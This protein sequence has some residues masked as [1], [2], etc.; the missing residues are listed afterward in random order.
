MIV[1]QKVSKHYKKSLS[2][3]MALD[4]IDLTVKNNEFVV[5]RGPSGSGK[6]TLLLTI[7][8]MLQP[9]EGR[10]TVAGI[11]PYHIGSKS[12]LAFRAEKIGFVFQLFHLIPYLTVLENVLQPAGA[13]GGGSQE[14]FKTRAKH[15]LEQVKLDVRSDHFP[16]ELSAGEKQRAAIARAMLRKPEILLADEPT[17]NLDPENAAGIARSLAEVHRDGCTVVVVTHGRDCDPY[18]GRIIH[19]KSGRICA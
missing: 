15:L 14:A 5:I 2:K 10:L 3:V 19:L 8:G 11:D 17:G 4:D 12:R 9:T 16:A 1:L 18:T 13:V 7:G 6:T